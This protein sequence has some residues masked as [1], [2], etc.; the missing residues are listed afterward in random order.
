MSIYSI[1][2]AN[3]DNNHQLSPTQKAKKDEQLKKDEEHNSGPSIVRQSSLDLIDNREEFEQ[4]MIKKEEE[5]M[6]K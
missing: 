3:A 2:K 6:T 5:R 1:E 4:E